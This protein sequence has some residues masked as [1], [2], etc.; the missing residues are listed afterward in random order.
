MTKRKSK[1]EAFESIHESIEAPHR[2]G[3]IDKANFY[4]QLATGMASLRAGEGSDG[5][6]FMAKLDAEL[7]VTDIRKP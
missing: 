4:E 7:A 2:T 1:S 6:A 3:V 5:E